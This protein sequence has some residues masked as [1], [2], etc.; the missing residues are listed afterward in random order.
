[1]QA[2]QFVTDARPQYDALGGYLESTLFLGLAC[3]PLPRVR[4]FT[5]LIQGFYNGAKNQGSPLFDVAEQT[6][7]ALGF[8]WTIKQSRQMIDVVDLGSS[9]QSS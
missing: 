2:P 3:E 9:E 4:V 1:M 7:L 8:V 6:R 5:G